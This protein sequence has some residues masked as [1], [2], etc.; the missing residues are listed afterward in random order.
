MS[1][2]DITAGKQNKIIKRIRQQILQFNFIQKRIFIIQYGHE[3]GK[4]NKIVKRK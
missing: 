1:I 4:I 2:I 3:L